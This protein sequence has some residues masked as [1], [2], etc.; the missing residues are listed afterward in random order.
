[1]GLIKMVKL[2]YLYILMV[3]IEGA[4][5]Y[6]INSPD[7]FFSIR[8]CGQNSTRTV[9]DLRSEL[10]LNTVRELQIIASYLQIRG[11]STLNKAGLL[12]AIRRTGGRRQCC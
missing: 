6:T 2:K 12:G 3:L 9:R 7:D 4:R 5:Y 8:V 11:R 10:E 1:M